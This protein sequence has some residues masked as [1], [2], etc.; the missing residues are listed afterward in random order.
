MLSAAQRSASQAPG[1]ETCNGHHQTVPIGRHGLQQWF[2]SGVH[3]AVEQDFSGGAHHTDVHTAG[4]QVEAP[5][6]GVCCGGASPEVSSSFGSR[7]VPKASLPLGSPVGETS[8]MIT[9]VQPTPYSVRCAPASGKQLTPGVR[10]L[11]AYGVRFSG[12]TR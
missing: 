7:L 1:G 4:V 12:L 11:T 10:W 8:S 2:R 5:V 6:K 9:G 3:R